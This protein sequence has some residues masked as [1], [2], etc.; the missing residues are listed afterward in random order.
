VVHEII[1]Q[2]HRRYAP[3]VA[4][5]TTT[6]HERKALTP[7]EG[8]KGRLGQLIEAHADLAERLPQL[9]LNVRHREVLARRAV[10]EVSEVDGTTDR[11]VDVAET[12]LYRVQVST[13]L[14]HL[15]HVALAAVAVAA[16]DVGSVVAR[17]SGGLGVRPVPEL[18]VDDRASHSGE[19]EAADGVRPATR[20]A[21]LKI[22]RR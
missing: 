10:R 3:A 12:V 13:V 18:V 8:S 15:R 2:L 19:V 16:L 9:G 6:D 7:L 21:V 22:A 1:E 5:R 17:P 4:L 11:P 20:T 14:E